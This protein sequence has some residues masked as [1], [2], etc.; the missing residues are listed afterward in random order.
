MQTPEVSFAAAP[1]RGGL[2]LGVLI[3]GG[4]TTLSN[5]FQEQRADRLGGAQIVQV[6]SSRG[7]VAGVRIA[8]D[9]ELPVD[10]VR[11]RD[12]PDDLRFSAALE[13]RLEASRCDLALLAGFLCYWH[14]SPRW[15]GRV[16]NIHPSLLPRFGGQGMF[17][18]RVHEAV[19]AASER[20]SGCTVHLVD[21]EYDHGP[22][23]AQSRV[24]VLP[25]DTPDTLA[26]RV[27]QAERELYP[28]VIRRVAANGVGW[29][30]A[31]WRGATA[32]G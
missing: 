30:Q 2:R 22:I 20:E 7:T 32:C 27:M 24:A 18:R 28:Q 19:L 9:A 11:R 13:A 29:L 6:I 12:F 21:N 23:V 14:L 15:L 5:L 8:R 3:S 26:A 10:I 25:A 4:G 31:A 17:G 16:L 1:R